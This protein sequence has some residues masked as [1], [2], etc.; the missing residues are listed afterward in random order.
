EKQHKELENQHKE[1]ENQF[2]TRKEVNRRLTELQNDVKQTLKNM[3]NQF[4]S[5][6]LQIPDSISEETLIQ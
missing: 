6:P 4:K 1:L 3:E 5:P 2:M